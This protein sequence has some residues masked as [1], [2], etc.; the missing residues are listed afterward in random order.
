MDKKSCDVVVIGAGIGGLCAAARLSYAGYK[1][2]VLEAL[3]YPGGRFTWLEYKGYKIKCGAHWFM[4][5]QKDPV[6]LTIKDVHGNADFEMKP[7]PNPKWRIG[8]KDHEMLAKGGLWQLI[9]L[10][11]RDKQ[12]EE[13]VISALRRCF[14]WREP[15]DHIMFS[16]WLNGITDNKTIY[17]LLNAWCVQVIG[18]NLHEI[19]AGE[20]VRYVTTIA[21][22]LAGTQQLM[23]NGG[24]RPAVDSLVKAIADNKGEIL[25]RAKAERIIV[26][27]GVVKGVEARDPDGEINIEAKVVVSDTGPRKTVELAGEEN[28]DR[29]YVEEVK[30]LKPFWGL[31]FWITSNGPLYD[32]PGGL[33]TIDTRRSC[34]WTD[35]SMIWPD[36]APKGK[37]LMVLYLKPNQA[38]EYDPKKEYEVFLAD[39]HETFP[40]FEKQG[41][42]VLLAR[43]YKKEWPTERAFPSD[44]RHRKTPVENLYNV[45][46]AVNSPGWIGGAGCGEGAKTVVEDI[47]KRIRV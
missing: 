18:P 39:L 6:L 22:T 19:S 8:G 21:A 46:D 27:D 12:E 31:E 5:G 14:R 40:N 28:F 3:P 35:T 4:Y 25:M 41:G 36:L 15:S 2:I 23:P 44:P 13:K 37:N 26:R 43:N 45:G 1:T 29:G 17:K 20:L 16:E 38:T 32:W 10:G 42:E 47:M 34:L 9:S 33:Y 24:L 11:A 30:Q 7:L